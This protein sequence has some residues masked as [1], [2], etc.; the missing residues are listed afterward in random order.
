MVGVMS[1]D[2]F[3][4]TQTSCNL[5]A[6]YQKNDIIDRFFFKSDYV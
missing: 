3:E 1:K 4:P 5:F 2:I 6:V